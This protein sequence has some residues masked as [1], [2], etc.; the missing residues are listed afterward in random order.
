MYICIRVKVCQDHILTENIW[1]VWSE[2]LYS[3]DERR[4][5]GCGTTEQ[6]ISEDRATQPIW[7]LEAE[8][9]KAK[10]MLSAR[11]FLIESFKS[12]ETSSRSHKTTWDAQQKRLQVDF[13]SPL[14]KWNHNASWSQSKSNISWFWQTLFWSVLS[15]KALVYLI[16]IR[17]FRN[18]EFE[19]NLQLIANWINCLSPS[20]WNLK[21][22]KSFKSFKRALDNKCWGRKLSRNNLHRMRS[23]IS[24]RLGTFLLCTTVTF[25]CWVVSDFNGC[26]FLF[27]FG[28]N[29]VCCRKI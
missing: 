5:H 1:V 21:M 11:L 18:S 26:A 9:R 22:F 14:G 19:F 12:C 16:K 25:F 23:P 3:E 6:R 7:K 17:K 24:R 29:L 13:N 15:N 8:F 28:I 4:C 20:M 27:K 10:I 2:T